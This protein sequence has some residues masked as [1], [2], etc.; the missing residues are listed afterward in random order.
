MFRAIVLT[1]L[2]CLGHCQAQPE[3]YPFMEIYLTDFY[4][5]HL[6]LTTIDVDPYLQPV[7]AMEL[8]LKVV[9]SWAFT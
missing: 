7:P 6:E 2:S 4:N 9:L 1:V 8:T 5:S 3:S